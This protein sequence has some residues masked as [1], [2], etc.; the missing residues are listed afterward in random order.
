MQE[1]IDKS[2]SKNDRIEQEANDDDDDEEEEQRNVEDQLTHII[3]TT[4]FMPKSTVIRGNTV[5]WQ[6]RRILITS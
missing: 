6:R 4:K 2:A 3:D 1:L 5:W